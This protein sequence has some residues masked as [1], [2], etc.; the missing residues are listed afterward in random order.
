MVRPNRRPPGYPKRT[1]ADWPAAEDHGIGPKWEKR[2]M[3][4]FS[5]G[6]D[7]AFELKAKLLKS[8]KGSNKR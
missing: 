5:T 8:T 7:F 6:I 1:A 2:L 3:T 4:P